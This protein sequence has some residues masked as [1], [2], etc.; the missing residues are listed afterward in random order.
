[1]GGWYKDVAPR[2]P[3]PPK[4]TPPRSAA[5]CFCRNRSDRAGR[6]ARPARHRTTHRR[7]PARSGG[8]RT[9]WRPGKRGSRALRSRTA[10][11]ALPNLVRSL[12]R[13]DPAVV[14]NVEDDSVRITELHLVVERLLLQGKLAEEQASVLFDALRLLDVVY[15]E[16][17]VIDRFEVLAHAGPLVGLV[18]E[19]GERDGAIGEIQ[20]ARK[21]RLGLA[22]DLHIESVAV[23]LGGRRRVGNGYRDMS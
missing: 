13:S 9:S 2:R 18:F 11:R 14:G 12:G 4:T 8:R 20:S 23:E 10:A 21:R 1:G 7:E 15:P 17:E 5:A 22:D 6:R 3:P 16:P 19:Q